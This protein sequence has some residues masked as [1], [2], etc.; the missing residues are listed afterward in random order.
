MLVPKSFGS[1]LRAVEN[2]EV[3]SEAPAPA[4]PLNL[5]VCMKQVPNPDLQFQI[6]LEGTD[7]RRDARNFLTNGAD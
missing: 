1:S 5:V 4:V 6:N 3:S 2:L 7:I